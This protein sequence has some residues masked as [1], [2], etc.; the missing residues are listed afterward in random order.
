MTAIRLLIFLG[1]MPCLAITAQDAPSLLLS[2]SE[3]RPE[4]F[5]AGDKV[6][7]IAEVKGSNSAVADTLTIL[8]KLPKGLI[9]ADPFWQQQ[10]N[11]LSRRIAAPGP[12]ELI[13]LGLTATILPEYEGPTLTISGQVTEAEANPADLTIS[14]AELLSTA[15]DTCLNIRDTTSS[16]VNTFLSTSRRITAWPRG[17]INL[18]P[19]RPIRIS[20]KG[21]DALSL[22]PAQ[23]ENPRNKCSCLTYLF[24]GKDGVGHP[25]R[26]Q[27]DG[28]RLQS[29][30][31][32]ESASRKGDTIEI[33][34]ATVDGLP[35]RDLLLTDGSGEILEFVQ[36]ASN[37][38]FNTILQEDRAAFRLYLRSKRKWLV[39]DPKQFA[40]LTVTRKPAAVTMQRG[41]GE[42]STQV[43]LDTLALEVLEASPQDTTWLKTVAHHQEGG[44]VF[45]RIKET[46]STDSLVPPLLDT[47]SQDSCPGAY[48][49]QGGK[50]AVARTILAPVDTLLAQVA[51]GEGQVV[52]ARNLLGLRQGNIEIDVPLRL[53][54]VDP[55]GKDKLIALAYWVG[56]GEPPLAAYELLAEEVP[57][58]WSQPGVSAPLAAYGLGHPIVL[59]ELPL[60]KAS[61]EAKVVAYD[62]VSKQGLSAFRGGNSYSPVINRRDG[63]PNYGLVSG[64]ELKALSRFRVNDPETGKPHIRFQLAYAN[65]HPINTYRLRVLVVGYYQVLKPKVEWEEIKP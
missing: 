17:P 29:C 35:L 7:L 22:R 37:L 32:L 28:G 64:K 14:V 36:E 13:A 24:T 55:P 49:V 1:I 2:L 31:K 58:D 8:L 41:N 65:R 63:R 21:C 53:D 45:Y 44:T 56:I 39:F 25:A 4:L 18:S 38:T 48:F 59:P 10:E 54:I 47:I 61:F 19:T 52:G 33:A 40:I 12:G 42:R 5:I 6:R 3:D 23:K 15:T 62:F 20:P 43:G 27:P 26:Y 57:P 30:V 50:Q 16:A 34:V 51:E 60:G 46:I 11:Q 9:S